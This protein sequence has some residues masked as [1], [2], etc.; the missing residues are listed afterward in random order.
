MCEVEPTQKGWFIKY[1]DRSPAVLAREQV[2]ANTIHHHYTYIP[3]SVCGC[4]C[5][6]CSSH[7]EQAA[8]K[9]SKMDKDDEERSQKMINE[10]IAR[11]LA[12]KRDTEEVSAKVQVLVL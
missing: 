3:H 8:A 6:T 10:Q 11:A 9:K 5:V 12:T 2:C 4:V 1:V 7:S